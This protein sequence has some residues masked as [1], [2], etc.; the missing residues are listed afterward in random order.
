M[1]D[2]EAELQLIMSAYEN[3]SLTDNEL[4]SSIDQKLQK[5]NKLQ[6]K[7]CLVVEDL[8][9]QIE[10]LS[11]DQS[12]VKMLKQENEALI[13]TLMASYDLFAEILLGA[14]EKQHESWYQQIA[15]QSDRLAKNLQEV[16]ITL[17]GS[18]NNQLDL[19]YHKVIDYQYDASMAENQIIRYIKVGY[20][21]K[22][23]VVRK[24]EVIINRREEE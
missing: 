17:I 24:A 13:K 22:G 11:E 1:I 9:E 16:G 2:V 6:Q 5:Q 23:K 15:L 4:F 14:Y 12:Q 8:V 18:Q 3:E 19:L 20:I 7:A 21:Y 10:K